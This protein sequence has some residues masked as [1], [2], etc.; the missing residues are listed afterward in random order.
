MVEKFSSAG[1]AP[2]TPSPSHHGISRHQNGT[3]RVHCDGNVLD[4]A[5]SLCDLNVELLT[6]IGMLRTRVL[7]LE[8]ENERLYSLVHKQGSNSGKNTSQGDD[9]LISVLQAEIADLERQLYLAKSA[10][11]SAEATAE[12][13]DTKAKMLSEML[14]AQISN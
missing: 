4:M 7:Q 8:D 2:A 9:T 5:T 10:R 1:N 14:L 12:A 11:K 3:S 13:L 6:H